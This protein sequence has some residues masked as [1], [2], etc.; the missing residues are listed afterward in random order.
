MLLCIY[1]QGFLF[2]CNIHSRQAKGA[3]N[4]NPQKASV[5]I[6]QGRTVIN[7]WCACAARVTVLGL[8]VCLSVS[9]SLASPAITR[10]IRDYQILTASALHGYIVK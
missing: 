7:L 4:I 8:C 10:P 5:S 9:S 3:L 1:L 6:W 2:R